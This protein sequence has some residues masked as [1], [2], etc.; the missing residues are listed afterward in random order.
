[1][2]HV[3]VDEVPWVEW[4]S[5]GGK[6]Q[7]AGQ[8]LSEAL[9]AVVNATLA[10]G[11]HPFDLEH[12]RLPPGRSG[13]PFHSHSAQW[14]L[15]II[16]SGT[17][18]V[19]YGG[20]SRQIQAG[21]AV[22]HPP[23]EAHQLTNTGPDELRY[24]LVADNPLTEFWHYPDSNKWGH[25]P[26]GAVFRREER[27]YWEGED[28]GQPEPASLPPRQPVKESAPL[29]RFVTIAD[30]PWERRHSPKGRFDSRCR[31]LSLALGGV[32]DQDVVHGGH[33]FDVQIRRVAP[34]AAICPFHSHLAQWELFVFTAGRGTVR[35]GTERVEVRPGD[36]V[37]HPPGTPYQTSAHADEELECLIIADNPPID[38]FHYPESDKWGMR[39][40]RKNFRLTEVDYFDGEE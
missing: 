14:E 37:L 18:T 17:G 40:P 8:Q 2:K 5:P 28:D 1:M 25:R 19:R 15:F 3:H 20:R 33:P 29:A 31:D 27:P 21:E 13:C 36:V 38:V 22:L 6:F 11:G 16:L 34:G 7:A 35:S 30:L 32:R 24:Y 23:G 9:G 26:G 39:P 10:E 4:S 12:G